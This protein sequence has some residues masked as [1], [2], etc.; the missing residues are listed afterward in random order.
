[1]DEINTPS[2]PDVG[3]EAGFFSKLVDGAAQG[4]VEQGMNNVVI[5]NKFDPTGTIDSETASEWIAN[6]EEL[7][8]EYSQSEPDWEGGMMDIAGDA[9]YTAT[10]FVTSNAQETVAGVA[11]AGFGVGVLAVGMDTYAQETL[12]YLRDQNID[13]SD[14]SQVQDA[15]E[16]ETLMEEAHQHAIQAAG[17]TAAFGIAGGKIAQHLPKL[18]DDL[19]VILSKTLGEKV[20]TKV[21][22]KTVNAAADVGLEAVNMAVT[23]EGINPVDLAFT[24]AGAI[25]PSKAE[26]VTSNVLHVAH[27]AVGDSIEDNRPAGEDTTIT[28]AE[29]ARDEKFYKLPDGTEI[30]SDIF[31]KTD[32]PVISKDHFEIAAKG[33]NAASQQ[34]AALDQTRSIQITTPPMKIG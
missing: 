31:L 23:G 32:I 18:S 11:T 4:L 19:G 14:P 16:N 25:R 27:E 9:A 21:A 2:S 17:T 33:N 12:Q 15:L 20:A 8:I 5:L 28:I 13:L 1:M 34:H 7:N 6:L 26:A 10:Q 3:T 29:L 30:E 22:E 24:G